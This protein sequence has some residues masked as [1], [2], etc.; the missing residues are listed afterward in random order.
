MEWSDHSHLGQLLTYATEFDAS[1]AI[2]VAYGFNNEHGEVINWLNK[3]AGNATGFYGVEVVASKTGDSRSTPDLRLVASPGSEWVN[4]DGQSGLSA[5]AEKLR[6]FF[7]SLR[8]D[9]WR[10]EFS[11]GT[12]VGRRNDYGNGIQEF[13]S[14]L[15]GNIRYQASLEWDTNAWASLYVGIAGEARTNRI[16]DALEKEKEQI[17]ATFAAANKVELQW[18]RD[19]GTNRSGVHVWRNCSI[20]DPPEKLEETRAWMVENLIKFK[21]VFEPRLERILSEI[22]GDD[23]G[24]RTW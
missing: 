17:E 4:R 23:R 22:S 6:G 7:Q 19:D 5:R 9:L 20:E 14:T 10:T 13:A 12:P 16:F 1:A 24:E 21:A 8:K 11:D 2:W 3:L 15:D 18:M